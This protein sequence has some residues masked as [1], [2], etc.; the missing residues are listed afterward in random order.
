[1]YAGPR[2]LAKV[3]KGKTSNDKKSFERRSEERDNM[4][5]L[6]CIVYIAS[7]IVHRHMIYTEV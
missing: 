2:V 6:I 7:S 5:R 4:T 3:G 1:V